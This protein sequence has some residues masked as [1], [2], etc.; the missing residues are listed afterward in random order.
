MSR[1][2]SAYDD[3][4]NRTERQLEYVARRSLSRYGCFGCH[5]IPGYE[6]AKPIGTPLAELGP[7]G[8]VA[9][10]VRE[11]RHVPGNARHRRDRRSIMMPTRAKRQ[12]IEHAEDE[13]HGGHA[14]LDPLDDKYDADTAYF[15]QSLNSH[16]RHGFLWQKLRMPRSFDYETTRTK[17]YDERL[18]MPK[19]P[20]N[21]D[22]REAVMTFVLG[23][24]NEAPAERYIYKPTPR[25]EAIVQG[26]HVLD[27]YNCAGCHILDM[28]RWEIAFEPDWFEEPPH[29][30]RLSVRD[31]APSRRSRSRRR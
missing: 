17:R 2:S 12:K 10:R 28:E 26:R 14:E 1:C 18:R 25:Q 19:F 9:A 31:S 8:H 23:L 15:L 21:C 11:H 29:D 30:D 27:K 7:Q 22:E 20:F 5:D 16:Q 24:T 13:E 3:Q 4:A 6:T